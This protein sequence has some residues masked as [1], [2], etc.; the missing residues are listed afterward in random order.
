MRTI[1]VEDDSISMELME[2]GCK[3]RPEVEIVG[4][5]NDARE[6]L[7]YVREHPVDFALL[8]VEL[9]QMN[10]LELG[11]EFKKLNG[12]MILI[13]VTGCSQYAVDVLK[14]KAD[15]CI[16]KPCDRRDIEDAVGRASLL[17]RRL[18]KRIRVET[19]GRFEAYVE[20]KPLYFANSKARELFAYCIHREGAN[21]GMEEAIDIL[22]PERPYD[23]RVKRL[24]RK[25]VSAIQLTLA[26]R[27][28][29]D[30][31]DR[32]R[33]SCHVEKD[34]LDCDLFD[35]VSGRRLSPVQKERLRLGYMAEYSWA[36]ERIYELMTA[37]PELFDR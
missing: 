33:G 16:M 36:E 8:D 11:S 9:P 13:Y 26:Q 20:D 5:Y 32:K 23:E 34:K 7:T 6:A 18:Q 25:A 24:Y 12:D 22:W 17:A 10:G 2:Q 31:F 14:S 4:K 27:G 30:V 21:V 35:F 19:F 15:Y 28:V 29:R 3:S 1:L 37:C